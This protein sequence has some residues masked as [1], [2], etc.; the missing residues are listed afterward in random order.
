MISRILEGQTLLIPGGVL[1]YEDQKKLNRG[2]Q[3]EYRGKGTGVF[4]PRTS[5]VPKNRGI[6]VPT[7][8]TRGESKLYTSIYV[9]VCLVL[10]HNYFTEYRSSR[11]AKSFNLYWFMPVHLLMKSLI[12]RI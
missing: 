11:H 12:S 2:L 10:E 4:I 6:A 1:K 3:G 9:C 7:T 8:R 5:P